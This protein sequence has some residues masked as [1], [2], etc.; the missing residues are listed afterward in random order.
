MV[1]PSAS[2]T[3]RRQQTKAS[4]EP[5]SS[6]NRILLG[7]LACVL[8]LAASA[9]A[10]AEPAARRAPPRIIFGETEATDFQFRE[11]RPLRRSGA[12][13]RQAYFGSGET[14]GET[15]ARLQAQMS[16]IRARAELEQF[17]LTP[18]QEAAKDEM[19][20]ALVRALRLS[21]Q[22]RKTAED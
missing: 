10:A 3:D 22:A 18:A 19:P 6:V 20:P 2:P 11:I 4:R 21:K 13:T 8:P 14:Y 15:L 9:P 12:S 1:A 17:E 16:A 5:H 7:L